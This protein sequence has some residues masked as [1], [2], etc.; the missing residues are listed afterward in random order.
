[1]TFCPAAISGVIGVMKKYHCPHTVRL[2]EIRHISTGI[3]ENILNNEKYLN[4]FRIYI[5]YYRTL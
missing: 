1:M 2:D 5:L 4:H 3:A